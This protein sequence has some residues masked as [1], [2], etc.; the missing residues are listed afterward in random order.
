MKRVRPTPPGARCPRGLAGTRRAGVTRKVLSL[1][2]FLI[3][4]YSYRGAAWAT[5]LAETVMF[6]L[7]RGE[8]ERALARPPA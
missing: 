1:N 2:L 4:A 3:P 7:V 5:I 8:V 6:F